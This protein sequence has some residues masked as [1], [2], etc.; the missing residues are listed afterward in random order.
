MFV[1][2]YYNFK[3]KDIAYVTLCYH[4]LRKIFTRIFVNIFAKLEKYILSNKSVLEIY[5]LLL[6]FKS[7]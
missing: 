4:L 7:Y 3:S 5:T 6:S 2:F 1:Q